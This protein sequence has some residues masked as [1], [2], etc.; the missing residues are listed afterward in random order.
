MKF[1]PKIR[2]H[3]RS[4]C[5]LIGLGLT[6]GGVAQAAS[7]SGVCAD[8]SMFVVQRE[9]DIPCKQAKRV[10]P[11]NLPPIRPEYLPRPYTWEMQRRAQDENNPYNLIE[12]AEQIRQ[13]KKTPSV[14]S[15]VQRS[16]QAVAVTPVK[17]RSLVL[18]DAEKA[19]LFRLVETMQGLS[20]HSLQRQVLPGK[21]LDLAIAHSQAFAAKVKHELSIDGFV[22]LFRVS[23]RQGGVFDPH[24][25]ISQGG[26]NYTFEYPSQEF[27]LLFG[28]AGPVPEDGLLLGYIVIPKTVDP[29]QPFWLYWADDS[30]TLQFSESS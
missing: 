20:P 30:L 14:A 10:A 4:I 11:E 16:E 5:L 6:W 15:Q 7:I 9:A 25:K 8:G 28:E 21:T 27:N 12:R 24:F 23:A 3:Q 17:A 29:Q 18:S 2:W 1:C 19:D 26:E 13:L 22:L